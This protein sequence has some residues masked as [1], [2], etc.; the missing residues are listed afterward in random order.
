MI[1]HIVVF[2]FHD[3]AHGKP[4][5]ENLK[6]AKALLEGLPARIKA[7]KRMEV[8]TNFGSGPF[9]WDQILISEFETKQD[10]QAYLDHPEHRK[11]A[12]YLAKVRDQRAV[13][14]YE[15]D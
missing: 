1:R 7:L 6:E 12:D 3:F 8:G 4:K 15:V 9:H 14:D 2:K 10:L 13:V 5:P 11:V